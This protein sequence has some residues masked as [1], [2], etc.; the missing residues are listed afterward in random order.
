MILGLIDEAVT[1]DM[2]RSYK[3]AAAHFEAMLARLAARGIERH[4]ILHVAQS[5]FHD[6][7]PA[8]RLGLTS[9]WVDRR[10]GRPGRGLNMPSE[11]VPDYRVTTME[12]A[13]DLV[14]ALRAD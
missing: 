14:Q 13:A 12:E 4:H 10:A 3:P 9:L 6:I 7:A 1:A 8:G 5:R 2:V 11:A